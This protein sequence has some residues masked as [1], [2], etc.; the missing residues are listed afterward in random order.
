LKLVDLPDLGYTGSK[1]ELC[2]RGPN[3]TAGYYNDEEKTKESFK[4]GWFYTGDIAEFT[5]TGALR[6]I[7]RKKNMFKLSQGEYVAAE[8]VEGALTEKI[9]FIHQIFV[10][11]D[12]QQSSLVAIVVPKKDKLLQAVGGKGGDF[13]TVCASKEAREAVTKIIKEKAKAAGLHGFETP[14]AVYLYDDE[15]TVENDMLTP[16]LKP[17]RNVIQK[18]FQKQIDALYKNQDPTKVGGGPSKKK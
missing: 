6:I 13:S 8:K 9:D 2:I 10:Y 11:G 1:G 5:S 18:N 4:D 3:V 15:F 17:K 14:Q 7:D 16:T 12:S